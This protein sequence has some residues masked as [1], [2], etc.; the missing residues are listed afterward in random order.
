MLRDRHTRAWPLLNLPG[1]P[2]YRDFPIARTIASRLS[3]TWHRP[4]R[5]SAMR[6]RP[7]G[8]VLHALHIHAGV[9]FHRGIRIFQFVAGEN[10]D[11][12]FLGEITCSASSCR[13]PG[14]AGGAGRL[15]AKTPARDHRPGSRIS[16]S[17]TS[18]TT[19]FM[20]AS[21]RSALGRFT[22]RPI[23]MALAIV[24][25]SIIAL[26]HRGVI[27]LHRRRI[28]RSR[29]S[30]RRF[31]CSKSSIKRIGAGGVDDGQARDFF[32]QPQF[33]QLENAF[34]NAAQFPRFPPGTMT[35]SGLCQ[36]RASSTRY[37]MLFCPSRR[38]GLTLFI[39]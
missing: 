17:L 12:R 9:I 28:V 36:S 1:R 32:D 7:R 37:M 10:A 6:L 5:Q 33:L 4:I 18:R 8:Q 27:F 23:S 3:S 34:P 29:R 16:S 20:I 15:A 24:W 31:C 35:Q 38:K 13:R 22:G 21:A 2:A 19:P 30:R 14:H 39:R 11:D 26:I 25:A